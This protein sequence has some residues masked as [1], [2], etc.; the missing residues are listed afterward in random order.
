MGKKGLLQDFEREFL[1][2]ATRA[3]EPAL[4]DL[5]EGTSSEESASVVLVVKVLES[6]L[7]ELL[8]PHA[9]F[10]DPKFVHFP[11]VR[12]FLVL[13]TSLFVII[14]L[15]TIIRAPSSWSERHSPVW[16]AH[17]RRECSTDLL[18]RRSIRIPNPS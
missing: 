1:F 18:L 9:V 4:E 11:V 5:A 16:M 17:C 2:T 7:D 8:G 15:L 3:L 13:P 14:K 6:A 10:V 12:T